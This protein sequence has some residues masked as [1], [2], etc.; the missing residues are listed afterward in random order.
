MVSRDAGFEVSWSLA[1][2]LLLYTG[3]FR[4][5]IEANHS[6]QARLCPSGWCGAGRIGAGNI[7]CTSHR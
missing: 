1:R 3:S 6:R 2:A 7:E 4:L 5:P